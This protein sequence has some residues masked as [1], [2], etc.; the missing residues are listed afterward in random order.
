MKTRFL[1]L[2]AVWLIGLGVS[3]MAA[4]LDFKPWGL[5]AI[6]DGGRRKPMDTFARETLVRLSGRTGVEAAGRSWEA[7]EFVLSM[8]LETREWKDEPMILVGYRPLVQQLGLDATRKR[9]SVAELSGLPA[10]ETLAREAHELRR[11]S[12]ELSPLQKEVEAVSGRMNLFQRLHNGEVFLIIPASKKAGDRWLLPTDASAHYSETQ[13]A[14]TLENLRGLATAY[15][16]GAGF[17]FSLHA[18]RLRAAVRE[19]SPEVYPTEARLKLE[20]HYNHV[21]PFWW[22]MVL[23]CLAWGAI[24]ISQG[25]FGR[26]GIKTGLLR[27]GL[28][29][30]AAGL[31]IHAWGIA[32]RC[33]IAGRPPVTNMYE[34]VVWVSFGVMAFAACFF[35]RY[36]AAVYLLGALP[37]SALCLLLLRQLPI[38][39]PPNI[40][41]LVPVLRSNFW[42]TIHVLCIT[43]SYAAFALGTG[44]GHIVLFRYIRNPRGTLEDSMLHFWLYRILQLGVLLLAAGTSLGGVWAN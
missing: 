2:A 16:G 9:F 34:S 27:A 8:L 3:A 4:P 25:R 20:Y 7:S 15:V 18:N 12:K 19:L 23:Y 14:A 39:M 29:A 43:L 28:A 17:Q 41:P 22:A 10:L 40:D 30:A 36:R 24:W 21:D 31:L 26:A 35:A 33:I 11:K 32:A 37:V 38:A 1:L 5:L 44:F 42:L 6:Q 13:L